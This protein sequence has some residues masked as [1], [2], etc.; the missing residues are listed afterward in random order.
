MT[1]KTQAAVALTAGAPLE[2]HEIDLDEPRDDEVLVR[3]VATGICHTDISASTG[4]L[5]VKMPIVLGHEG[6]GIVERVGS[7]VTS[8]AP[9]DHVVITPDFCGTCTQCRTGHT[10]YCEN[11]G[12]L[13]FGGTRLDGTTK[14]S[15]DGEAVRAGFFGQSSFSQFSLVTERNI[16]KV[17][18]DAPLNMLAVL[19]CG[20]NAG[21]GA[22]L[23]ALR[24]DPE[25]SIAVF[26]TGTV[27]LAAI[28]AAKVRG[29]RTIIAVDRHESRLELARELGAT[30]VVNTAEHE[31]VVSA[32]K[33]IVPG[34]VDRSFD[35]T[36]VAAVLLTAIHVL[37]IRGICGFVA[38]TGGVPLDL[39]VNSM[40]TKG[41]Q[42]RAIMG[43]DGTGLVFLGELIRLYQ[44]GRLPIDSLVREYQLE[45]VNEAIADMR[46]G[47][48]I[49]PVLR[50]D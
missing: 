42:L 3:V 32:I 48:T 26:G 13:V 27:G 35:S 31:D 15:L 25:H 49:K 18:A 33:E 44:E 8:V 19:T 30:H 2:I 24:P 47:V 1:I 16:L 14:A 40:L 36:G 11:A 6:A 39:D 45:E 12:V 20:V 50:F 9:G 22:V 4:R 29:A 37:A 43:G 10:A 5:P 7:L 41:T 34:G 21:A 17:P 38:G 23:N 46:S 28:M